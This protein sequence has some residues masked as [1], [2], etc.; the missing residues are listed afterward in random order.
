M[1]KWE[2]SKQ[3][4]FSYGHRVWS[5]ELNKEFSLDN[6]CFCRFIHGHNSV[7]VVYLEASSLINGMV[8]DFKNLNWLKKWI[9]NTID[10]KF[11]MDINDPLLPHE[12][13]EPINRFIGNFGMSFEKDGLIKHAEGYATIN[14]K[15]YEDFIFPVREKFEG[16]VFVS[17]VPTSENLS[18]WIFEIIQEKMLK[19]GIKVSKVDFYETPKSKSSY[20]I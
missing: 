8:T 2:I 18:K 5:Q 7:L 15:C 1:R 6:S 16:M 17:F 3:F 12:V 9:D 20:S 4:E 11:I 10:H 19:I 13:S 14:P